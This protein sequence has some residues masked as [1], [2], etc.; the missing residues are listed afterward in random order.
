MFHGEGS[1]NVHG[2]SSRQ[3][4]PRDP[5]LRVE[6][7]SQT[8]YSQWLLPSRPLPSVG[9][10]LLIY[11]QLTKEKDQRWEGSKSLGREGRQERDMGEDKC[12]Y[13]ATPFWILDSG[14]SAEGPPAL[15]EHQKS[16]CDLNSHNVLASASSQETNSVS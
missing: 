1:E 11:S 14:S 13:W 16:L 8:L 7:S 4:I 12:H 5:A 6:R 2:P 15:E 10:S 9:T 3:Q